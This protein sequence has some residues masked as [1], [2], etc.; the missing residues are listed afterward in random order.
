MHV[1]GKRLALLEFNLIYISFERRCRRA[2]RG[3]SAVP[4]QLHGARGE[5]WLLQLFMHVTINWAAWLPFDCD[6]FELVRSTLVSHRGG[7]GGQTSL[8]LPT[9]VHSIQAQLQAAPTLIKIAT[10]VAPHW[11]AVALASASAFACAC[12]PTRRDSVWLGLAWLVWLA[13]LMGNQFNGNYNIRLLFKLNSKHAGGTC[14]PPPPSLSF[15]SLQPGTA[16]LSGLR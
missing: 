8:L 15:Q 9:L 10:F 7:N 3:E 4:D 2:W 14:R 16:T 5:H 13:F 6:S 11:L 1:L 12:A